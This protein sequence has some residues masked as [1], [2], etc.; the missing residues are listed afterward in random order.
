[1]RLDLLKKGLPAKVKS[2]SGDDRALEAKLREV[3]FAEDDE[4]EVVHI[5]P[6]GGKP[7]CVRLN[8]TLV[9]LRAEEAALIE[10]DV[11]P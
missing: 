10:V 9:A 2:L 8:R 3:G 5:G 1:M 7:I 6:L 11:T 4:I